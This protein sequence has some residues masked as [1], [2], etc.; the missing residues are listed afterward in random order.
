MR[1]KLLQREALAR[2]GVPSARFHK[3]AGDVDALFRLLVVPRVRPVIGGRLAGSRDHRRD[4]DE[5]FHRYPVADERSGEA[6][7]RLGHH[8]QIGPAADRVDDG[9]RVLGEPG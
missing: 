8:D 7:E 6:T 5:Q 2:A 4:Q 1:D 9:V 3:I